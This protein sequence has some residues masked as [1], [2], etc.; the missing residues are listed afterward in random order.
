MN[1]V[2]FPNPW[3]SAKAASTTLC[4]GINSK[5]LT[6]QKIFAGRQQS[7][8]MNTYR[9]EEKTEVPQKQNN[10]NKNDREYRRPATTFLQNLNRQSEHV[11]LVQ[12]QA[13]RPADFTGDDDDDGLQNLQNRHDYRLLQQQARPGAAAAG[14]DDGFANLESSRLSA[15]ATASTTRRCCCCRLQLRV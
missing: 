3:I 6:I 8:D 14:D 4:I 10:N 2:Q 11:L 5:P 13:R 15:N 1:F 9:I 7:W 12:Q